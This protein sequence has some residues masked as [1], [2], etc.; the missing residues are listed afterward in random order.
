MFGAIYDTKLVEMIN[1]AIIYRNP[2]YFCVTN[3][4]LD[5]QY[6]NAAGLEKAKQ[7]L[8][9]KVFEGQQ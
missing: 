9:M 8:K 6:Q 3:G 4:L 2:F 5:S 7:N 1:T